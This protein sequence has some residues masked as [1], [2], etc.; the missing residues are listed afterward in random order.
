MMEGKAVLLKTLS[1]ETLKQ[2]FLV[3]HT[4]LESH[5]NLKY[6]VTLIFQLR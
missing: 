5:L 2:H 1:G 3:R 6:D 4:L